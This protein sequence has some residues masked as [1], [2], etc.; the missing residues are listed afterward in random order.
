[1][2]SKWLRQGG[3]N[4]GN[5]P[6]E[7]TVDS[8][9]EIVATKNTANNP[10]PE[11]EDIITKENSISNEE[12]GLQ[13]MDPKRRRIE[14]SK[15]SGPVENKNADDTDM[16]EEAKKSK[17]EWVHLKLGYQGMFV[18]DPIGRS[19]GLALLWKESEQ[20]ELL[21]FS[22][23]HI[24]VKINMENGTS[25]RLTGLYGEPNRA[26]RSRTW[27][28]LQNLSRDSNLPWCVIGDV[29][30]VVD[31]RDKVGGSQ[32]PSLLIDGFNEALQDAGLIDMELV[33]HQFTWE[34]GK[35][36]TDWMEVCSDRALT[37]EE[38]LLMFPMAKLYNLEGGG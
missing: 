37:T 16:T 6:A 3:K 7:M 9:R 29:N 14:E 33:G 35:G 26:L 36:T 21:G 18:V 17:M 4:P 34:R 11:K 38:W 30:N 15:E 1:M 27:D 25:W 13:I 19:G 23:N 28:L 2:G 5:F 12:N 20:V 31:A 8:G 32:Y 10:N 22:Q 24:D